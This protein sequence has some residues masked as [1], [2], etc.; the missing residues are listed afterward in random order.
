M[1]KRS[2]ISLAKIGE[3]SATNWLT[4]AKVGKNRLKLAESRIKT[5]SNVGRVSFHSS[6][7]QSFYFFAQTSELLHF[8]ADRSTSRDV[9]CQEALAQLKSLPLSQD[10]GGKALD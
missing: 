4:S 1:S 2:G 10:Y 8:S 9:K 5:G 7:T 3:K 6:G